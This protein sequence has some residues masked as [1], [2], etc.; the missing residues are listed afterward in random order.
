MPNV[1]GG[2]VQI[3]LVVEDAEATA[4]RYQALVGVEGWNVNE[5]DTD[6]GAGTGFRFGG[7]PVS[8][9]A[10]IV[11]ANFGGVEIELIEPQDESSIYAEFLREHGP[12]IHHVMLSTDDFNAAAKQLGGSGLAAL[13]EGELQGGRFRLYDSERML[14]VIVE[15]AEGEA[16][17]PD[18][19]L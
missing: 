5:V 8:T 14:G 11:W 10:K 2:I 1:F 6:R 17:V 4:R 15:I 19:E 9:K 3:G 13:A 12:G 18:Q 7:R 16:L